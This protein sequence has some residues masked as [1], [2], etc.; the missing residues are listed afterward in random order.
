MSGMLYLNPY[1][2]FTGLQRLHDDLEQMR[3]EVPTE[4]TSGMGS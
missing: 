4:W 2:I 3:T 1:A